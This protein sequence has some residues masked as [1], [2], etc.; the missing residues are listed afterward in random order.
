MNT[1]I[2][3]NNSRVPRDF[4]PESFW[5]PFTFCNHLKV[6]IEFQERIIDYESSSVNIH[7]RIRYHPLHALFVSKGTSQSL[8]FFNETDH[9][10]KRLFCS[11]KSASRK[12]YPPSVKRCQGNYE[13]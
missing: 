4:F 9:S 5:N 12:P 1:Y 10:F 3:L 2:C 13:T 7:C 6:F 8:L 11:S